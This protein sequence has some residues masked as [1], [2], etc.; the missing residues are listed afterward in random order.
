MEI[1]SK[2]PDYYDFVPKVYG[3]DKKVVFKRD[4]ESTSFSVRKDEEYNIAKKLFSE[5]CYGN[6]DYLKD[7]QSQEIDKV[8]YLPVLVVFARTMYMY[9]KAID[10]KGNESFIT[11]WNQAFEIA[12]RGK[13]K[14]NGKKWYSKLTIGTPELFK[15]IPIDLEGIHVFSFAKISVWDSYPTKRSHTTNPLLVNYGFQHILD[16]YQAYQNLY[17]VESEKNNIEIDSDF[18]DDIKRQSKGFI[19][20]SFKSNH[21]DR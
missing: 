21:P 5:T 20:Q 16:P 17:M 1:I 9:I 6:I 3:V 12:E 11:D 10:S 7:I 2:K 4:G 14:T 13:R 8:F 18:N 15:G 19:D